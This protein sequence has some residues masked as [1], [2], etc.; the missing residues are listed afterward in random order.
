[1][2]LPAA[3][4]LLIATLA[5]VAH[6]EDPTPKMVREAQQHYRKGDEAF[7]AERYEEAYREFDQ[8]FALVPRPLFVLNMAHAQ[9]RRGQLREALALYRRYLAMDPETKLR[10]DVQVV[11]GELEAAIAAEDAAARAKLPPPPAFVPPPAPT[12]DLTAQAAPAAP[13]PV[14][15][16][17]WFWAG[18]GAIVAAGVVAAV[19]LASRD[20]Y[21]K[22]GSLG[23]LGQP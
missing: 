16:R 20:D 10:A 17:W 8:G 6:A 11:V 14:T 13:T 7:R 2:R 15:H 23:S 12:V 1:M 3:S 4:L 19:A 18:V 9:R 22:Q 5:G 21:K